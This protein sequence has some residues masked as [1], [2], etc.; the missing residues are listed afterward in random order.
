MSDNSN[1]QVNSGRYDLNRLLSER[2]SLLVNPDMHT[3]EL[4]QNWDRIQRTASSSRD[5]LAQLPHWERSALADS[6]TSKNPTSLDQTIGRG[7][8]KEAA[9]EDLKN[10]WG[11]WGMG[12]A[13]TNLGLG[14]GSDDED[15]ITNDRP[16]DEEIEPEESKPEDNDDTESDGGASDAEGEDGEPEPEG[17]EPESPEGNPNLVKGLGED[18]AKAGETAG[19]AAEVAEAAEGAAAAAEGAAAAAETTAV[20]AEGGSVILPFLIV[21]IAIGLIIALLTAL[22]AKYGSPGDDKKAD[23]TTPTVICIDPGHPSENAGAPGEA[24]LVFKMATELKVLLESKG[25]SVVMTKS[26]VQEKVL[27]A[28]RVKRCAAGKADFMYRI[29]GDGTARSAGY[30]YHIY[31]TSGMTNIYTAS[32]SYSQTIQSELVKALGVKAG[33]SG[34]VKD[35]GTCDDKT[36]TG[37]DLDGSVEANKISLPVSLIESIQLSPS[38]SSWLDDSANRA[39]FLG[40]I[41]SGI[42]K[43][44]PPTKA[45]GNAQGIIDLA[46]KIKD[47][48]PSYT[49]YKTI[50]LKAIT[51]CYGFVST[52][53]QNTV[54]K[55]VG[56]SNSAYLAVS[57]YFEKHPEK[58][59]IIRNVTSTS[60]LQPGDLLFNENASGSHASIYVGDKGCGCSRDAVSA[61]LND[62]APQCSNWYSAMSTAVR[63]K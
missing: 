52:V 61:S 4:S 20:V 57:N 14:T 36:C 2:K 9:G 40:G 55:D 23:G 49:Y 22:Y 1:N 18:A 11:D 28:E 33:T 34:P 19:K 26:T 45:G 50:M 41:S 25:Y 6:L 51:D 8:A 60:Q 46:C 13:G 63:L 48:A 32:K 56:Y 54:D 37:K 10:L 62:H 27:N 44:I 47:D 35:G 38:G 59:Q 3:T 31:P 39:K 15:N 58:Y 43:A 29:H 24:A 30:P 17:S 42:V 21:V 12:G 7:A 16:L 5:Q 53:V